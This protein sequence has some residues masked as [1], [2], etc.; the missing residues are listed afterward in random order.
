MV[1]PKVHLTTSTHCIAF[2]HNVIITD[3]RGDLDVAAIRIFTAAMK[4]L[5]GMHPAGVVGITLVQSTVPVGSAETRAESARLTR[6]IAEHVLHT[7]VVIEG[8]GVLAQLIRTIARGVSVVARND[9]TTFPKDLDEA[10]TTIAP[11]VATSGP[12]GSVEDELREAVTSVRRQFAASAPP[13]AVSGP[14]RLPPL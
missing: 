11:L 2:W 1:A 4:E 14:Y 12:R 6:D 5:L 7:A 8:R 10:L 9:R 3:V 13:R